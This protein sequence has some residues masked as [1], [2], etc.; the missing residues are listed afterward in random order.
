MVRR[1]F[2]RRRTTERK[3][4]KMMGVPS[5]SVCRPVRTF[6]SG[7]NAELLMSCILPVSLLRSRRSLK[8]LWLLVP[9]I[10]VLSSLLSYPALQLLSAMLLFTVFSLIFIA[11]IVLFLLAL[12]AVG[13]LAEWSTVMLPHVAHSMQ[14]SIRDVG[15]FPTPVSAASH[16]G[17]GGETGPAVQ[18]QPRS[19]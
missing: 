10:V 19:R 13:H 5:S 3:Q 7:L 8:W 9:A 6:G 2:A 12:F 1:L 16:V 4:A 15:I 14:S 11:L 18:C 17:G